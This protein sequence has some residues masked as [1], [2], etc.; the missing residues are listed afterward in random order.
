[1]LEVDGTNSGLYPVTSFG[2]VL[3]LQVLLVG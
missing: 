2:V 3:N 1:V